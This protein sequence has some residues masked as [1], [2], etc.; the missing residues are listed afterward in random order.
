MLYKKFVS[1]LA[2]AVLALATTVTGFATTN[3]TTASDKE[4]RGV[5]TP[6]NLAILI[7]DDLVSQVG[8]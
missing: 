5:V 6:V 4:Q 7:Q 1:F 8:N 3:K 2:L